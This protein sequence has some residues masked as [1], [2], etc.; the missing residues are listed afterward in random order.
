MNLGFPI[1]PCPVVAEETTRL[2]KQASGGY[3]VFFCNLL[4]QSTE[5]VMAERNSAVAITLQA[6]KVLVASIKSTAKAC[7]FI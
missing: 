1:N 7:S 3:F 5:K 4:R 2:R 6:F